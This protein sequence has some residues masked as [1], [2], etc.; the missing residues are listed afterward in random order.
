VSCPNCGAALAGDRCPQCGA[1]VPAAAEGP[2]DGLALE[3]GRLS[4]RGGLL[5]RRRLAAA[6]IETVFAMP[7]ASTRPQ[8]AGHGHSWWVC[9]ALKPTRARVVLARGLT[10]EEAVRLAGAVA[11]RLQVA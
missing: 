8:S 4:A 9:A 11:A 5:G 3:G 7:L 10:E 6:Q 2:L 1:V